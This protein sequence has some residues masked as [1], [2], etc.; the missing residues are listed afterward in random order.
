MLNHG[1]YRVSAACIQTE[2][3]DVKHN[4]EKMIEVAKRLEG[5]TQLLV[6]GELSLCGY[7]CQDLFY[8]T[9]LQQACEQG[10]KTLCEQ[11]PGNMLVAVGL[12]MRHEGKLY[13]TAAFIFQGKVLGFQAKTFLPGYNEFYERRWF[14]S[15]REIKNEMHEWQGEKI[16]FSNR[17]MIEDIT[18]GA[19]VAAEICEDLWVSTP[20]STNHFLRGANVVVNLSAS[21]ELIGKKAYREMLVRMQAS[22][23]AF[24]Y[25]YASQGEYESTSDMLCCGHLM[26][27]DGSKLRVSTIDKT[28]VSSEIDLEKANKEREK[29]QTMSEEGSTQ[30]A[31]IVRIAST[32]VSVQPT[33]AISPTPFVPRSSRERC[34]EIM[35]IQSKALAMRLKKIHCRKAV[36]G[37]SGGLDSTLALLITY[38]AFQQNQL[39]PKGIIAVTMPGFGTTDRTYQNALSMIREMGATLK[40]ISIVEAC[41]V[42]MKDIG[43]DINDHDV[44]YENVQAR[45]RT[46]ILMDLANQE[47]G[48]VIG[49]GDLSEMALGFCTYNGDHM[50]MYAVNA[51]I[52]KTLVRYL[53]NTYAHEFASEKLKQTLL[54]IMDTPVSPELLPPDESGQIVQK[55]EKTIG[56]YIYHDFF[57]YYFLRHHFT[58]EKIDLLAKLAFGED[59]KTEIRET[60]KIFYRRFFAQQFKRN[61]VPDGI[62]VGSVSLSPRA[63]WRMPSEAS[64]RLWLE[65]IEEED[66]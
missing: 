13:N 62:K 12:P 37:I 54:D 3:A 34:L 36:I 18:T 46:Q 63:D 35:R 25:V 41:K 20:V 9:L 39:D 66:N 15:A 11:L 16:P 2:I 27:A 28:I 4:V 6:F 43:H 38:Q 50:S 33:Y 48:I 55:T 42:H 10:L 61:C 21:D 65:Q 45:E 17:L 30:E 60:M 52:P 56:Q 58:P 19:K 49:T 24:G 59:K 47:G 64:S 1:F 57:L 7:S 53:V 26:I 32:P 31:L 44:T 22:K 8:E 14:S 23:C 51:S 40:E 5:Q 29:F